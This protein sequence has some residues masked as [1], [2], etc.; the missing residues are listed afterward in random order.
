VAL[1]T[2]FKPQDPDLANGPFKTQA[3]ARDLPADKGTVSDTVD[4]SAMRRTHF[5]RVALPGEGGLIVK[6]NNNGANLSAEV[7]PPSGAPEKVDPTVGYKKD[8]LPAGDYFVKV[9]ANEP[10]DAGKYELSTAFKQGDTCKNGGPACTIEGA[11]ELKLPQD[12][13]TSDVDYTKAKQHHYYK[14]S[15]KEK[16]RLTIAFKVLQPP[17]GSKVAA[18]F[19]KNADD[20]G[21][22]IVGTSVTKDIEAP[23]DYFIQ[24]TAPDTGEAAKYALQTIWQ[25]A[26]F[27]SADMVEKQTQGQCLLTV[28]A[29]SNQ[30]V[31]AGSSCTIVAGSNP[32]PIDSCVVDQAFPN[33]SKV[34]PMGSCTK[35]PVQN[36]KVQ[37]SQ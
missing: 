31:R 20:E 7:V 9:F 32:A 2:V 16:G 34:R 27:I 6:F 36:V 1:T 13:K 8:D 19:K 21:D 5:W 28:S 30:G 15:V 23:G 10:G 17:R 18:Y 22:K 14:A 25:P 26:N 29:G 33:L 12:S 4:Y 37:I 35:I 11:E 24:V 3:G